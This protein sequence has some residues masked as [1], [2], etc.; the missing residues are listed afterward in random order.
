MAEKG[1]AV[2]GNVKLLILE[3]EELPRDRR[4]GFRMDRRKALNAISSLG[5]KVRHDSGG[6]LM[7]V[8]VPEEKARDLREQ[9]P[10]ARIVPLDSDVRDSLAELDST[11]SLFLAALRIRTSRSYREQKRR[12]VY[13]ESPEE[14][15]LVSAPDFRPEY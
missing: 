13:G 14:Q 5:A 12:R 11:E 10:G 15:E 8:E 2:D 4:L 6:R 7:L 9:L 3:R 1:V